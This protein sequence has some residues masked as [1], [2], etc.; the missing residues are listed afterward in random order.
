MNEAT[1]ESRDAQLD[2]LA[3][4]V[5]EAFDAYGEHAMFDIGSLMQRLAARRDFRKALSRLIAF[6]KADKEQR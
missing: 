4:E 1:A 5:R 6:A 2:R 3:E